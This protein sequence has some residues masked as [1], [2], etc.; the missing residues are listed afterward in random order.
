MI[1]SLL[2]LVIF[3]S[4]PLISKGNDELIAI[5]YFDK[6][7]YISS[8]SV[9]TFFNLDGTYFDDLKSRDG[10]EPTCLRFNKKDVVSYY[11][12]LMIYVFFCKVSNDGRTLVRIGRQWKILDRHTPF[13]ILPMKEYLTSLEIRLEKDDIVYHGKDKTRIRSETLCRIID[14]RGDFIALKMGNKKVWFQWKN[15][16]HVLFDRLIYE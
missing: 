2:Y 16:Y 1:R 13:T 7:Q 8:D 10:N 4:F 15:G 3:L 6:G 14:A 5:L 12:D 11:P 9:Y